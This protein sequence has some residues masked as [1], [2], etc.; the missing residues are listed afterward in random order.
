MAQDTVVLYFGYRAGDTARIEGRV[1]AANGATAPA[2][3]DRARDNLNRTLDLMVNR[4]RKH[5]P[6]TVRLHDREMAATTDAEGY[7]RV[8]FDALA[9]LA[10]GWHIVTARTAGGQGDA[11]LLSLPK[12]NV[13]GIVSDVDDTIQITQVNDKRRMLANTFMRN[14]LQRQAV[15]GV[16]AFYRE[17]AAS[18][19]DPAA[20][21]IFYLSAS[22]HQL[23]TAIAA[24]LQ[25]NRFPRGVLLT[26]RVTDDASSE[27][28]ADQAAYKTAKLEELL[29][30]LPQVVF[31]LIGDDGERDPEIYAQIQQRFPD[32]VAAVWIRQVNPDPRRVRY[33]GQGVLNDKLLDYP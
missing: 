27:P 7:L 11:L 29:H 10:S 1:I 17:L 9:T 32:R 6:V 30:R 33:P 22:P 21:P 15:P 23:H 2:A 18:N 14:P 28:L 26:K 8:E 5:Y 12:D 24:F 31:T 20:A 13:H 3:T 19:P 16:A 4:E 25:H